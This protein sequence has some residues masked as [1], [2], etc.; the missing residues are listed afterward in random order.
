[1]DEQ[2]QSIN[3]AKEGTTAAS[4]CSL[5]KCPSIRT[6]LASEEEGFF[7][8]EPGVYGKKVCQCPVDKRLQLNIVMVVPMFTICI[9]IHHDFNSLGIS[10]AL[11]TV[12]YTES[13]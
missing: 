3:T 9:H 4:F 5:V 11:H 10:F 12:P 1:M 13:Y 2:S 6:L 8:F 7:N